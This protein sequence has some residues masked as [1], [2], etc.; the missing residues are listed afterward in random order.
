MTD[1]ELR[2]FE[3]HIFDVLRALPRPADGMTVITIVAARLIC[4]ADAVDSEAS[5]RRAIDV[6]ARSILHFWGLQNG[7]DIPLEKH[8]P[9]PPGS[10]V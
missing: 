4:A 9:F 10:H 1:E 2:F 6:M 5:A 7:V 3:D 8:P